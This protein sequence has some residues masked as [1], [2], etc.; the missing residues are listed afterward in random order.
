[1]YCHCHDKNYYIMITL[2]I[3]IIIIHHFVLFSCIFRL[4]NV[5]H[6]LY[7]E[8]LR[9]HQIINRRPRNELLQFVKKSKS[10]SAIEEKRVAVLPIPPKPS[11]TLDGSQFRQNLSTVLASGRRTNVGLQPS[12]PIAKSSSSNISLQ[13]SD[14]R[15]GTRHQ[16]PQLASDLTNSKTKGDQQQTGATDIDQSLR[17]SPEEGDNDVSFNAN[18]LIDN[19]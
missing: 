6:A 12:I 10:Q 2:N 14:R 3:I 7:R 8:R 18:S 5:F 16:L 13:L 19:H 11:P 9:I 1:M 4:L 15:E 17:E